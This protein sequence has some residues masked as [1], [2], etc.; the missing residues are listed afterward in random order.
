MTLG[1][2]IVRPSTCIFSK[3]VELSAHDDAKRGGGVFGAR[4]SACVPNSSPS[5]VQ[6]KESTPMSPSY[7]LFYEVPESVTLTHWG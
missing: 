6:F 1:A 4:P 3:P 7:D 2:F 5:Q